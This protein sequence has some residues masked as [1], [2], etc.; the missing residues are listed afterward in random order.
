MLWDTIERVN[1]LRK[2]AQNNPDYIQSAKA[3]AKALHDMEHNEQVAKKRARKVQLKAKR[4]SDIYQQV[5]FGAN[6]T[7][8]EH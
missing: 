2:A 1:Q 4:L 3:H 5:E 6:P 8:T 7:G